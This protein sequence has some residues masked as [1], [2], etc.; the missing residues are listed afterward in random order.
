MLDEADRMLDMGFL[1]DLQRIINLLPKQRQNLM[2]SATF[3]PEIR[4]L[5]K[6]FLHDPVTIEV[7]RSN[8]TADNVDQLVFHVHDETTSARAVAPLAAA[9]AS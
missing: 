4:R 3:S 9:S 5:A 1:P 8:A 6:S 2:F 7:A